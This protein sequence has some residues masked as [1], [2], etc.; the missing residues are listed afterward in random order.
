VLS[1]A[2]ARELADEFARV[3]G[4]TLASDA[5]ELEQGWYFNW[6][7]DA[8]LGSHG[9]DV[10]DVLVGSHGLAVNKKTGSIFV[11]G[12]AFPLDRDLRMYDL[13]MDAEKHDMVITAVADL[14]NTVALLQRIAPTVIEP[15]CEHGT[16]WRIPRRLTEV[17]I[18]ARLASLPAVFPDVSLYF[19]FEAVEEARSSGC[20][21]IELFQR[22]R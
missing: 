16:V 8:R 11:F 12:S 17:E 10:N 21:A 14:E 5:T 4:R 9:V 20:C 1:E 18:R 6:Q 2:R 22:S 15:S 3:Q 7:N 19:Q 13:G